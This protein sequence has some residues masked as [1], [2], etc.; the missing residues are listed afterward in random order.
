MSFRGLPA[1]LV[2]AFSSL[3]AADQLSEKWAN[4]L[5]VAEAVNSEVPVQQLSER[6]S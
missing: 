5:D 4:L 3:V 1:V 6:R 2:I